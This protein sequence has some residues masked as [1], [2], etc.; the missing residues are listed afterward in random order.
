[1]TTITTRMVQLSVNELKIEDIFRDFILPTTGGS[2]TIPSTAQVDDW[3]T[4]FIVSQ[5]HAMEVVYPSAD[6]DDRVY[7]NV[8]DESMCGSVSPCAGYTLTWAHYIITAPDIGDTIDL[9]F[10]W[11]SN[12]GGSPVPYTPDSVVIFGAIVKNERW[13]VAGYPGTIPNDSEETGLTEYQDGSFSYHS[14]CASITT[15]VDYEVLY[16]FSITNTPQPFPFVQ[17][18][19][20]DNL[21]VSCR[22][23]RNAGTEV[24]CFTD[25]SAPNAVG[26]FDFYVK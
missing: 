23:V 25:S 21:T 3:L 18:C 26:F 2:F 8:L 5:P 10:Q 16:C 12:S 1:M 17:L 20:T 13:D 24:N 6:W 9:S 22:L 19:S 15:S 14:A 4:I 7:Q 11:T